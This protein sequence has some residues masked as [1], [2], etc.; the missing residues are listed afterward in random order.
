MYDL[1]DVI[2][3]VTVHIIWCIFTTTFLIFEILW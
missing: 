2:I 3:H 1:A